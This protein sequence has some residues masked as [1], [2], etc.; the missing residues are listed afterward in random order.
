VDKEL[1]DVTSFPM[2]TAEQ[3]STSSA[4]PEW[5]YEPWVLLAALT[6]LYAMIVS[7]G[8]RRVV[9]YDELL[10]F[11]IANAKTI[12]QMWEMIRRLDFQT[13]LGYLLS[14][15]SMKVLGQTPLGLRFPS[16]LA[17]Y[18][19]SVAL[20]FYVR[21][22]VGSA[23]AACA[24][25]LLW[26]GQAG[27]FAIEAR[28]YALLLMFF[29]IL[30]L[31][32]ELATT[33]QA[34]SL[35]LWSMA[36]SNLGM[37][38]AHIFGP[39]SLLPFLAAEA[40]RFSRTRKPDF[41]LWAALL[42][43]AAAVLLYLP[44]ISGYQAISFPPEFQAS[45]K[46]IPHFYY[47]TISE[48]SA[49]LFFA[50]CAALLAPRQKSTIHAASPLRREEMVLFASM[51]VLPVLLIILLMSR[52]G[53]FWDRYAITTEAVIYSVM[54]ILLGLRLGRNRYAGY[55]AAAVLLVFCIRVEVWRA[56]SVPR[57]QDASVLASIRPDLPLVVA[58]GV[59]FFE[60]NHR[61]TPKVLS[62]MYFLK[63]RA[64]ALRYT[65]TNLFEDRGFPNH[66]YP[67]LPISAQVAAY[68]DFLR[69]HREFLVLGSYDAPEEWLLRKLKDDHARLT[70]L[71]AYSIPY[72]DANLYLVDLPQVQ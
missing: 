34:R 27:P 46:K 67:G 16:I 42:L 71:G 61:E 26:V 70:W 68:D 60:M 52:R 11:D 72:V 2:V 66:M 7:L 40:A 3:E 47:A 4:N 58:G 30:L 15:F 21:R 5:K 10:T 56:L 9:W 23:Y 43:P 55:A 28:P 62:R 69:E 13:P 6:A 35:A 64:A 33:S 48:I 53:A 49:A 29:A 51:F 44:L 18:V 36:C 12:P 24:V 25:L 54:A 41:K 17:F 50:L 45:L 39:L 59:T 14:R 65:N 20:F 63:D 19:A 57:H 38:S 1:S 32:W 8:I 31:S 37:I 22:K